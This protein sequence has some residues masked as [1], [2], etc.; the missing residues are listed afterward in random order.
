MLECSYAV[1]GIHKYTQ[2]LPLQIFQCI[3]EP[4]QVELVDT[5]LLFHF[6]DQYI[7]LPNDK[8]IFVRIMI[9]K[10]LAAAPAQPHPPVRL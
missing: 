2:T 6:T 1:Y 10:K 9:L 5:I 4:V 7:R 3:F 8:I